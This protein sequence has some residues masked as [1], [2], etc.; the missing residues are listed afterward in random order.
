MI[1]RS[2]LCGSRASR[3]RARRALSGVLALVVGCSRAG[4]PKPDVHPPDAGAPPPPPPTAPGRGGG[5]A[6]TS[7][8]R[9][10]TTIHG[11]WEA[12]L[13]TAVNDDAPF[14]V[15]WTTSEGLAEV[16]PELRG[17]GREVSRGFDVR[18]VA[19]R[20]APEAGLAG[21]VDLV[22]CDEAT[23]AVC[24]PV[25]RR[26]EMPFL[27][28]DVADAGAARREVRVPLPRAR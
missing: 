15:R 8:S 17:K 23:H 6:G 1:A 18:V 12:P 24:V 28:S 11:A 7:S 19:A 16:P 2:A 20:G 10:A 5:R 9:T 4:A 14:H 25:K 27:V 13:G 26:L 3:V 21:T 22:V